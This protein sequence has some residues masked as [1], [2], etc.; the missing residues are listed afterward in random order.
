VHGI[1]GES[2]LRSRHSRV[3]ADSRQITLDLSTTRDHAASAFRYENVRDESMKYMAHKAHLRVVTTNDSTKVWCR[4]R[5]PL[6]H[7]NVER[8]VRTEYRLLRVARYA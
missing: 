8:S 7:Q 5:C 1:G 6:R 3:L 2:A 4:C